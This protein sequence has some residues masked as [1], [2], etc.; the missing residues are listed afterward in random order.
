MTLDIFYKQLAV[1]ICFDTFFVPTNKP[2]DPLDIPME[3]A[4]DPW[5]DE[6]MPECRHAKNYKE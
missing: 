3:L 6:Q 1:S 5:V 4:L 2:L